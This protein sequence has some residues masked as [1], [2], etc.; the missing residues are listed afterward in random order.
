MMQSLLT[1]QFRLLIKVNYTFFDNYF[2]QEIIENISSQFNIEK[3]RF[4]DCST[5]KVNCIV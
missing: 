1:N 4:I 3:G 2:S 5:C